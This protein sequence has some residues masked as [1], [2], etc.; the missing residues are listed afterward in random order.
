[1]IKSRKEEE[2]K[3]AVIPT[4]PRAARRNVPAGIYWYRAKILMFYIE[5][6]F[7]I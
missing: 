5:Y 1:M 2:G 3:Q 4:D 6:Q 7:T